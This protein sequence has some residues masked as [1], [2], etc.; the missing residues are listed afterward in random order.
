MRII[1]LIFKFFFFLVFILV[2]MVIVTYFRNIN[3]HISLSNS[4]IMLYIETADEASQGKLQVNWKNL[5]A[6]DGVRYKRD[7][8]KATSESIRELAD[9]FIEK[10]STSHYDKG[11]GYR[12]KSIDEIL[13]ELRFDEKQTNNVHK[14]LVDLEHEGLNKKR[15]APDSPYM[16]FI[17]EITDEA[18]AMYNEY[19]VFPSITIAQAILESGWGKSDL[20]IKANNLFGIKADK[21][22]GGAYISMQTTE[23]HDEQV[24][25][26]FRK[27]ESKSASLEDHGKFI[28]DNKR[29]RN[30]GVFDATYYVDQAEALERAGYSTKENENGEKIYAELLINLIR[31]YNLQLIDHEVQSC[32]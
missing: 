26:N 32:L 8:S 1:K 4:D 20:S 31:Q 14:Y 27:Y 9:I 3:N 2:S 30:N 13:V 17:D 23:Y 28:Y 11:R 7:F 12:L 10:K 19:G 16:E 6:I 25:S 5:A 29:Y 15:L 22:W 21:Y 24:K 18:I